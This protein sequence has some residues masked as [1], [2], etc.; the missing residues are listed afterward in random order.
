MGYV[1]ALP[2]QSL[3]G[4]NM[5]ITH[6]SAYVQDFTV[7]GI[8]SAGSSFIHMFTPQVQDHQ[9]ETCTA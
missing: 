1:M 6:T 8:S 9:D 2:Q 7:V 5:R 4:F 3:S